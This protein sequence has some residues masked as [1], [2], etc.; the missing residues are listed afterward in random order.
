MMKFRE[1]DEIQLQAQVDFQKFLQ[2][3]QDYMLGERKEAINGQID[4]DMADI[5]D[6]GAYGDLYG[7]EERQYP[8]NRGAPGTF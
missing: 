4:E 6:G 3:F 2:S 1:L 5:G 8:V 7:E